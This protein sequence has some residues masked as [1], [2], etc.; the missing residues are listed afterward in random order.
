LEAKNTMESQKEVLDK[1]K[2]DF[3]A[4]FKGTFK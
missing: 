2:E 4:N 1:E 3:F